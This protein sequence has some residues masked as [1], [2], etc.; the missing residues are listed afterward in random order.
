MGSLVLMLLLS[1]EKG[2]NNR[3]SGVQN[4]EYATS[5]SRKLNSVYRLP[6]RTVNCS[7]SCLILCHGVRVR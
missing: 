4:A 6:R 2:I 7:P 5:F 3:Q 1:A